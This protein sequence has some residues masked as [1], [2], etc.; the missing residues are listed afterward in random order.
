MLVKNVKIQNFA[1]IKNL[2]LDFTAL[3]K[4]IIS[5]IG[6]N[7]SGKT[8]LLNS[9]IITPLY[10]RLYPYN[11]FVQ[12]HFSKTSESRIETTLSFGTDTYSA[13]LRGKC[14]KTPE[15]FLI[16]NGVEALAGPGVRE[17]DAA[18]TAIFPSE[19]MIK[20]SLFSPQNDAA[21]FLAMDHETRHKVYARLMGLE[22]YDD[23]ITSVKLRIRDLKIK[24]DDAEGAVTTQEK[25]LS[26]ATGPKKIEE[27]AAQ[28]VTLESE[29][30]TLQADIEKRTPEYDRDKAV[31]AEIQKKNRELELYSV[32]VRQKTH[33]ADLARK[34][35]TG[36]D[37]ALE[38]CQK[39][40]LTQN[41]QNAIAEVLTL[42]STTPIVVPNDMIQAQRDY[43]NLLDQHEQITSDIDRLQHTI[44]REKEYIEAVGSIRST[45][46]GYVATLK[47]LKLE[48]SSYQAVLTA[49]KECRLSR[50]GRI[51][52]EI[53]GM[54]NNLLA[55]YQDGRFSI[56]LK[57]EQPKKSGKK[58][59][60]E[61]FTPLIY[62]ALDGSFREDVSGG[63]GSVISAALKMAFAIA[64]TNRNGL[65]RGT[66]ILD[67]AASQINQKFIP[68]YMSIIRSGLKVFDNII[69]VSHV[70]EIYEQAD[71]KIYMEKGEIVDIEA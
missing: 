34:A 23:Y 12:D 55:D 1:N 25:T 27:Y 30:Q 7:G 50:I 62:D 2:S 63:E 71:I 18:V 43:E 70:P 16:K 8:H 26:L 58:E 45:Y 60:K 54:C 20:A 44:H 15:C 59:L 38:I 69:L 68:A 37:L 3:G 6:E 48:L 14:G 24:I 42:Q 52:P 13:I 10:R 32:K 4:G 49:L 64:N 11:C 28:L 33:A 47:S 9:L 17:F 5:I 46:D 61:N 57:T 40:P 66:L 67:E 21:G 36:V 19:A 65:T 29:L 53:Q 41:A 51:C 31:I 22:E 35:L 39:C 56:E